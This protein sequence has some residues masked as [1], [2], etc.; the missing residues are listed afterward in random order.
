MT[1][2]R[3]QITG[4][5]D[6]LARV[7]R[8]ELRTRPG[9]SLTDA[10]LADDLRRLWKLGVIEDASIVVD[11]GEVT[12]AL[13]PRQTITRVVRKGGDALAQSRFRQLEATPFEP[14]RI[15]RM[16]EALQESYVRGGRLD[17]HVEARQR[18]HATG[19]DVCVATNPGPRV[20]IGRLEFPGAKSIPEKTLRAKLHGKEANVNR[21]GGAFD[22]AA[23]A[24]DEIYLQAEYWE[25]GHLDVKVGKPAVKRRGKRLHVAIPIDEGP[26]YRLGTISAPI[27]VP[28]RSGDVVRRSSIMKAIEVLSQKLGATSVSPQTTV[29]RDAR[30]VDI[31]FDV[32]WRYPWDALRFWL[33]RSR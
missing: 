28:L 9:I 14:S 15:R 20:T 26:S 16:A 21:V 25:R 33:S 7:L 3:V 29:D 24:F 5:D 30:R 23:L 6:R 8:A 2:E 1:I 22:E 18:V 12:F 32:E 4:V 19:V 27:E 11:D 13:T 31:Y 10:P 17:A